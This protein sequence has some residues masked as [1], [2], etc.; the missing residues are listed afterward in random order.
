M[1]YFRYWLLALHSTLIACAIIVPT[2]L[3]GYIVTV[4]ILLSSIV[5]VKN[6]FMFIFIFFPFRPFLVEINNGLTYLGDLLILFTLLF[7]LIRQRP[8]LKALW[9]KYRFT[10]PFLLVLAVGLFAGLLNGISP[11]A[12]IFEIR[13]LL[14]TFL[15]IYISA[16]FPWKR[17]DINQ[18]IY[19][20]MGT[21]V[22]ISIHGLIEKLSLRNWLLPETWENLDLASAN[23]MRIYGLVG[24]PNVL[25]TYLFIVFF[26]TF[27]LK[28]PKLHVGW[29]GVIRVLLLGTMLLT[30]SRGT[31]LAFGAGVLIFLIIY[32]TWK[33][34]IPLLVYGLIAFAF[35]YYPVVA[36]T[37][38]IE[39]SGYFDE[40]TTTTQEPE[41]NDSTEDTEN[42]KQNNVFIERF[43][44][45]FSNDTIQASAEWGR[46]YVV[47]KGVEVF[48]DHPVIGSGFATF[49]D[50]ATQ[51]YPSPIYDEYG[52]PNN[53]YADNQYI[54]LLTETGVIG[55][56]LSL[57]FVILLAIKCW[58]LDNRLWR[59]ISL[60]SLTVLLAAG[61]FY[62]ILE[63][64]TFTLY[65]YVII[66]YVLNKQRLET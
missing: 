7:I 57:T 12:G 22:I 10:L 53:L 48:L 61:L 26:A 3:V 58:K 47:F 37:D 45:M 42:Q 33:K 62:N 8:A 40:A 6:G 5:Y 35:I 52:I 13:A 44:E 43:K 20:S 66:G 56:L 36:A 25:A 51:S 34:A 29:L 39:T 27:L 9:R 31:I 64:K 30:Y 32:R 63:D 55:I 21:A 16:E 24:N 4:V 28:D 17:K 15:L 38:A 11:I 23:A 14:I 54:L 1:F 49:G 50:A 2:P 19:V 41:N 46:L 59:S 60:A 65:F 18:L